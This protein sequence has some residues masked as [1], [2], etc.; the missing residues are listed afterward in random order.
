MLRRNWYVIKKFL[1]T[2]DV[3][4]IFIDYKLQKLLYNYA[5]KKGVSGRL[6]GE[7]P[8]ISQWQALL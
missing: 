4:Y 6:F 1:D 7:G 2:G 5:K 8:P 3:Q